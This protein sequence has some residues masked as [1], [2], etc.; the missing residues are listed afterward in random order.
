MIKAHQRQT[1]KVCNCPDKFDFHVPDDVWQKVVPPP[2]QD[3]VVCLSCFDRLAF[4][5]KVNYAAHVETLYFAGEAAKL[6]FTKI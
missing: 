1:C 3:D 4:D 6:V 2:H 5:K